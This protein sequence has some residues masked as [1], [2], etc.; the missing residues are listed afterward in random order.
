MNLAEMPQLWQHAI[1]WLSDHGVVPTLAALHLQNLSGNPEDIAE[2]VMLGGIQFFIIALV[3]RPLESLIPIERWTD[4]RSTRIDIQYTLI[5]L[6]GLLPLFSYLALTPLINYLG[7]GETFSTGVGTDPVIHITHWFPVLNQHPLLL[8]LVYY[9]IY[10]FVY[11]WMHRT[12]HAIPWLWALHSLHHSQRQVSCWTND[13]DCYL[14][15]A[16]ES[17]V[18][19][20]VGLLIGVAPN[21][22]ALLMLLGELVQNFSHANVRI[23]FGLIFEKILVAPKFHR[24]HHMRVDPSHPTLHNCN[25]SQA[26]PLWDILFG[27]AL[28]GGA[29]RPTGVCDPVIDA[30][31][32]RGLIAQQLETL[33]R[34]WGAFRRPE[35]WRLG[36][37]AFGPGYTPIPTGHVDLFAMERSSSQLV[38]GTSAA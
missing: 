17:V 10:D 12:Q 30:D 31:N 24:L 8:F 28:Y 33:K 13:R 19:A 6:L 5:A 36:D 37:V 38:E 25:F 9:L 7:G 14:A 21:E 18:L 32:G 27:T 2:A 23:G 20:S 16:L 35:G 15:G 26:F 1:T 22:F 11:Y 3:F 4:R 29:I 34:F